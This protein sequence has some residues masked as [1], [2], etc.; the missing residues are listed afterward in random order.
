MTS[1]LVYDGKNFDAI[2]EALRGEIATWS[3]EEQSRFYFTGYSEDELIMY[4]HSLGRW[5]RNTYKLWEAP[6]LPEIR[7]DGCDYSPNHPDA[8]SMR[9]IEQVWKLGPKKGQ[10]DVSNI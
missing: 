7:D 10:D 2:V 1:P 8:I 5:V 3:D 9:I 6:W 4:H